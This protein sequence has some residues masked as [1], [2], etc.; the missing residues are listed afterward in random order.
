MCLNTPMDAN[1]R[2]AQ[3]CGLEEQTA[4]EVILNFLPMMV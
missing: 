2:S 3:V 1:V 4:W